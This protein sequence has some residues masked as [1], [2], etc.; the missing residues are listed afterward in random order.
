[1]VGWSAAEDRK[2]YSDRT[3]WPFEVIWEKR[4]PVCILRDG[5]DLPAGKPITV[6]FNSYDSQ[7][8]G[9]MCDFNTRD[10]L[11]E[12]FLNA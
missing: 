5:T 6:A 8:S 7:S 1:M 2:S 4:V 10:A 11:I 12:S 9:R 3:L